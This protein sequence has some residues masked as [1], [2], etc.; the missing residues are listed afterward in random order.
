[1]G[2]GPATSNLWTLW[3]AMTISV[4]DPVRR[5]EDKRGKRRVTP[6]ADTGL[7][8]WELRDSRD[9]VQVHAFAS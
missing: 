7:A 4:Q 1:M 3:A 2:M 6:L 9:S 5:D 8:V